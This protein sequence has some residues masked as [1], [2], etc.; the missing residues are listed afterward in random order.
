MSDKDF[1]KKLIASQ[2]KALSKMDPDDW[3]FIADVHNW[4]DELDVLYWIVSQP[5]CDKATAR[6][7]FWKGEPTGYDFE[8]C[9]EVM[10]ES[11][12]SVEPML[13]YIA[14]RFRSGGFRREEIKFDILQAITG[15][16][17]YLMRDD[18]S[19]I[20]Y[21]MQAE[22]DELRDNAAEAGARSFPED[23]MV[24]HTPGRLINRYVYKLKSSEPY[25]WTIDLDTGELD[26]DH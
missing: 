1:E 5:E 19:G 25:P 23:L 8:E 21:G 16:T 13:K 10:G 12:Y 7:V 26:F 22:F 3:H 20:D 2:I 17:D 9:E 24:T 14:D 6:Q 11:S 18:R 4:D 15:D